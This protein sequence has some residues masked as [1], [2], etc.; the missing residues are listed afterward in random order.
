MAPPPLPAYIWH[1]VDQYNDYIRPVL[2]A[3]L[4]RV[5]SMTAPLVA[6]GISAATSGDV[7]S[8]AAFLLIVYMTL[9][10]AEYV[11]RS[12]IAWLVFLIKLAL[13]LGSVNVLFYM[14]RVGWRK[15][16]GDAEWV[17]GL[18]WGFLEETVFNTPQAR[19][20]K[21]RWYGGQ[22]AARGDSPWSAMLGG[23]RQ[24]APLG[25]KKRA[26]A[27]TGTGTWR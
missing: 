14:N 11:R 5:A 16:L 2:P 3:P 26:G 25:G 4:Q 7:V 15:A 17:V 22:T 19:D 20:N 13:V 10:A 9:R 21:T 18:L 1:L 8:L 27:G 12:V 23:A 6:S 24:Q